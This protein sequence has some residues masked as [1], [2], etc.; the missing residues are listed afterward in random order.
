MM[1]GAGGEVGQALHNQKIRRLPYFPIRFFC[2]SSSCHHFP[3]TWMR[4][5]KIGIVEDNPRLGMDIREKL[6]LGEGVTVVWEARDGNSALQALAQGAI[7]DVVLMDI[8]MRGMDGIET[9]RRMK[10]RYPDLKV[11]MLTVMDEEQTLF[12]ALQA[13]A[14]GYL[15]KDSKPH[16]LLNALYEV[17]EGG[18]PL[19]PA[20]A[21][22]VNTYLT[23]PE[24]LVKASR[25]DPER[26]TKRERQV[27]ELLKQGRTVRQ[28]GG[29]LSIADRT[30]RGY[31]E[32]VYEKLQVRSVKEAIAKG[33]GRK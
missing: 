27:L 15:L 29:Q 19:S 10:E 23:G 21:G 18:L 26:L 5:L 24:A 9:T 16:L 1:R 3:S 33:L 12:A 20:L 4:T 17:L 11:V 13:G 2:L 31:L 22:M 6:S 28:I 8:A 32:A 7:P 25:E 30:V 14:S